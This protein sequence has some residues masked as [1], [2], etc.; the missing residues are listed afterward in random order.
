MRNSLTSVIAVGLAAAVAAGAA[1]CG[2]ARTTGGLPAAHSPA[3]HTPGARTAVVPERTGVN[4]AEVYIQVL[5]RYL[6]TPA[7]NSFPGRTFKTVYVLD[8]AYQD[9]ADPNG[10][11]DRGT[12]ITAPTRTQVTAA[13]AGTARVVFVASRSSVI[14][15]IGCGIVKN[16]GILITLGPPARD[17]RRLEVAIN[18]YVAC[19][20]ATWLTYILQD[21]PGSGWH[22]TGTTGTMAIS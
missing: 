1:G 17:A 21:Q 16:D 11:H 13:L 22:V 19:L 9:A 18:G 3:K 20:G 4:A 10:K 15:P 14:K 12:P 7:E 5:R 6:D 8:L 2:G